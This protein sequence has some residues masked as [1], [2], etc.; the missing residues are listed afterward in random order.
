MGDRDTISGCL[1]I[2]HGD[3]TDILLQILDGLEAGK[4]PFQGSLLKVLTSN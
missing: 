1:M 3:Q 4:S 2:G